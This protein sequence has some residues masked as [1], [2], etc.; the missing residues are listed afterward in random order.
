MGLKLTRPNRKI[1]VF[2]FASG[3]YD[4]RFQLTLDNMLTLCDC[5]RVC[6]CAHLLLYW[7]LMII[8]VYLDT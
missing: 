1:V 2:V 8:M 5:L 7:L 6:V 4:H 3:V